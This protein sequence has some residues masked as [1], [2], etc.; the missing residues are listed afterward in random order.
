M[1]TLITVL[2]FAIATPCLAAA[3]TRE[4]LAAEQVDGLLRVG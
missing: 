1:R 2:A 4:F 3:Q